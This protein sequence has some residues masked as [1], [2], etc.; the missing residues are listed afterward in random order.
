M[1]RTARFC[2]SAA[3]TLIALL[4]SAAAAT[5]V[6]YTDHARF[7]AAAGPLRTIGFDDAS[8][9]LGGTEY[10]AAGL[11][12]V[13]RAGQPVNVI[14]VP[15]GW[16][17]I[18]NASS[19]PNVVSSSLH[20]SGAF[21]DVADDLD[22]VFAQ[23]VR[24]A[25]L[26]VGNV[27]PATTEI[28]L[29]DASGRIVARET[30]SEANPRLI[31]STGTG[32]NRV[33]YGAISDSLIARI[34]TVEAA[35]DSDGITYD[36]V[37][38]SANVTAN[39]QTREFFASPLFQRA[40]GG[41]RSLRTITFEDL[42]SGNAPLL[43]TEYETQG[44]R[45]TSRSGGPIH[46]IDVR[47]SGDDY[48]LP[49]N[50]SS[51]THV[52]SSSIDAA[53]G[54]V[55]RAD[56]LDFE[57]RGPARA[58][59]VW[60]GNIGP[61]ETTVEALAAGGRVV[62]SETFTTRHRG[63]IGRRDANNRVF[64]GVV[65]DWPIERIRAVEPDGDSDGV[66]FDDVKFSS[67]AAAPARLKVLQMNIWQWDAGGGGS[68]ASRQAR[69]VEFIRSRDFDLIVLQEA[70]DQ[71]G[72]GDEL[73]RLGYDVYV[74]PN[75][76]GG[77]NGMMSASRW[78]IVTR[79][80]QDLSLPAIGILNDPNQDRFWYGALHNSVDLPAPLPDLGLVNYKPAWLPWYGAVREIQAHE[81]VPVIGQLFG[82]NQPVL[83]GGD[84]D[85]V[86]SSA[87]V[88][89]VLGQGF[90]D[91]WEERHSDGAAPSVTLTCENPMCATLSEICGANAPEEVRHRRVDHLMARPAANS[92]G[93]DTVQW[94]NVAIE[95][96][97]NDTD[98]PVSGHYAVTGDLI[99]TKAD[100]EP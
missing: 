38:F 32:D 59:G 45:I 92:C 56:D 13:S 68:I 33:F 70:I 23:P 14:P 63:V 26:W 35:G 25:G 11:T 93:I 83:I 82:T 79:A 100:C 17:G 9:S 21:T 24:A 64:F 37:Q 80:F 84:F 52:I 27:G 12:I 76:P 86:T 87:G 19:P 8:Q 36:D 53:G 39:R 57:L 99:L 96:L 78:P 20:P 73:R 5:T 91:H 85:D 31:G 47:A 3:A 28:E 4:A 10:A 89:F 30:L 65:S 88:Q 51:R 18:A 40:A 55:D 77:S 98:V 34:R 71:G 61:G 16:A 48:A 60:I 46:R 58:A 7:L 42:A 41:A 50:A 6:E 95:T 15:S 49:L 22:F 69:L 72:I 81:L 75:I 1:S 67:T 66:T 74:Q 90:R 29:L 62:A 54:F 97:S 94:D 2:R 44:L 43:G